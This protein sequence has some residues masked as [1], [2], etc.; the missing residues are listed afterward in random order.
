MLIAQT[1]FNQ[2]D[3]SGIAGGAEGEA[4]CCGD[5]QSSNT[6]TLFNQQSSP[7]IWFTHWEYVN[8]LLEKIL[9]NKIKM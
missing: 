6:P 1:G 4:R 5:E 2:R 7:L 9:A 8:F 3:A